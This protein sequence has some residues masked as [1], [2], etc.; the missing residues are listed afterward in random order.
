MSA[1]VRAVVG[2]VGGVGAS[3]LAA[4]LARSLA[5]GGERVVLVDL[6][7]AGGGIDVLLGI[8]EAAGARG[9]DLHAV[10]GTVAAH[11]LDGLLPR[12]QGVEVLSADRSAVIPTAEAV[13]AVGDALVRCC[14][15]VVVD[16]PG[17]RL[18]GPDVGGPW[19]DVLLVT[20]QDVL[21]VAGAFAARGSLDGAPT[22]LVLRRRARAQVASVEAADLLDLPLL[23]LLPND[24]RLAGGVDRGL[25]PVV[26]RWSRLGRAVARVAGAGSHGRSAPAVAHRRGRA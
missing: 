25:G 1:Q 18:G 21:G 6:D 14:A 26:G 22:R 17:H 16:L 24:R 11:D 13:A 23:A 4:L 9:S 10:R 3:T 20:G 5:S 2:A 7:H 8:E 15:A 12:W 19:S